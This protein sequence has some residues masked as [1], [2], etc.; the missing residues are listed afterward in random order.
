MSAGALEG[1][2]GAADPLQLEFQAVVPCL[3]GDAM[4]ATE[5]NSSGSECT[6]S[7]LSIPDKVVE[8]L[9]QGRGGFRDFLF[10]CF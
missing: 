3:A 8:D 9:G 2:K 5:L 10:W 6:G 1:Q 7:H 4:T